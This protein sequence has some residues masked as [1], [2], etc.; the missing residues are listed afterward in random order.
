VHFSHA[1]LHTP[2]R[3]HFAPELDEAILGGTD[4]IDHRQRIVDARSRS[5]LK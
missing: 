2:S 3:A 5:G 4:L 1:A